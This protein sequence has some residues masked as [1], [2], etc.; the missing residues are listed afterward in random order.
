MHFRT[1]R[2]AVQVFLFHKKKRG[3]A[4]LK[5][6]LCHSSDILLHRPVIFSQIFALS[7]FLE[8]KRIW[9]NQVDST[10]FCTRLE[11]VSHPARQGRLDVDVSWIKVH[12]F[13][14]TLCEVIQ[15]LFNNSRDAYL[16]EKNLEHVYGFREH[17]IPAVISVRF[18]CGAF[19]R[20]YRRS[21]GTSCLRCRRPWM[22]V[23]TLRKRNGYNV[24]IVIK[25]HLSAHV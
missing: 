19:Y 21:F 11:K 16:I 20:S 17:S 14:K 5:M 24:K 15:Y 13:I 23:T 2:P 3:H 10:S 7:T 12:R 8:G 9:G 4:N 22:S 6:T 1:L 25:A 18:A